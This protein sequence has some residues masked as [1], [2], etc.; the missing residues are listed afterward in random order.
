MSVGAR[1]GASS[2]A[3]TRRRWRPWVRAGAGV[4]IL[5]AIAAT[6][7]AEPFIRGLGSV[8]A[9]SAAAALVLAAVATVAAAWRWRILSARLGLALGWRDAIA[10]YYRS[11]FLN[12]V[13]PG[14]VVGDVHRAVVHGRSV[15]QV[16]Q[17]AR[18]VA[19]E[20]AAGQTVQLVLAAAVLV[21]IGFVVDAA[22]AVPALVA[23]L[24]L[25]AGGAVSLVSRRVRGVARRE[26]LILGRAFGSPGL[27]LRIVAASVV[28][29]TAHVATFLVACAAVGVDAAPERLLGAAVV[30]VLAS[31]IP[32]SVGGW[33]PREGAAA[34]AFAAAGLG[35]ALGITVATAY[36]VLAMIAL[37]PGAAVVAASALR[38]R[39]GSD[40]GGMP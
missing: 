1:G 26:A 14:G 13:L 33:G 39:G 20:R 22:V 17:A 36:G 12:T 37:A 21:A 31:A 35:A 4:A 18:A 34:G 2:P 38:R 28:V 9:P 32:L 23:A 30:A 7:G 6:V 25:V 15:D 10:A 27:A 8:S 29:V 11:Q 19:A 5:A 16:A 40:G 24:I 3:I